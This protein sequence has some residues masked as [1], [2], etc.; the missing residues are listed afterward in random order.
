M[1]VG[2]IR[3]RTIEDVHDLLIP[4]AGAFYVIDRRYLDFARIFSLDQAGDF[5][6]SSTKQRFI[7]E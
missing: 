7:D 4:E 2:K 3:F 1:I 6:R 5:F